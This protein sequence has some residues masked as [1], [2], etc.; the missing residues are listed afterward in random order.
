MTFSLFELKR[1]ETLKFIAEM[2]L[3]IKWRLSVVTMG[4]M[5]ETAT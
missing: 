2:E 3:V 4:V 5:E 1:I